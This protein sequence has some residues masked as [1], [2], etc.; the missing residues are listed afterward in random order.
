M[1]EV[2]LSLGTAGEV[3]RVSNTGDCKVEPGLT[4]KQGWLAPW[5]DVT[6][7][8]LSRRLAEGYTLNFVARGGQTLLISPQQVVTRLS[9]VDGSFTPQAI[10]WMSQ[11]MAYPIAMG[12]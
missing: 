2:D 3:M 8:S 7:V 4:L 1:Q 9:V 10:Q 12:L 11:I 6:L 5:L